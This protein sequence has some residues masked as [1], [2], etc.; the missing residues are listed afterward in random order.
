MPYGRSVQEKIT[1]KEF[2]PTFA[3]HILDFEKILKCLACEAFPK[4]S[5]SGLCRYHDFC[6][7]FGWYA[8]FQNE[9]YK[10]PL[11]NVKP[12]APTPHDVLTKVFGYQ[13]FQDIQKM[14][15][16]EYVSGKHTFISMRTG[17]GKTMCYWISAILRGGLT[18]VISPLVSLIDD[19]VVS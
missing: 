9:H 1:A 12:N 2:E 3:K 5:P 4:N 17:A 15:I 7:K 16:L 8:E 14:A 19:Q 6:L 13:E 18:V 11:Q 10:P